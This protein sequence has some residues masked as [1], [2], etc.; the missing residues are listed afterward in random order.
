MTATDVPLDRVFGALADP[1]RRRI[2]VSLRET[3][4]LTTGELADGVSSLSRWAVMKH[5]AVL[6]AAGLVQSLPDGRR[7]RHYV[8]GARLDEARLW[9]TDIAMARAPR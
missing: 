2:V 8:D 7:R 9:L 3:P 1:T 4:G 5:L 6:R